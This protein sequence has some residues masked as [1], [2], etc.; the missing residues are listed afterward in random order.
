MEKKTQDFSMQ[1]AV[2]AAQSEA[3]Q[4]LLALLQKT[5]PQTLQRAMEQAAAGDLAQAKQSL[6]ALM[7]S[8]EAKKLMDRL[9]G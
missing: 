9:G 7:A 8:P 3:G 6:E 5:D 2:R 1:D 4:Q